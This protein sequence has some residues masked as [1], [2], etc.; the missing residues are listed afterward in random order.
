MWNK[1]PKGTWNTLMEIPDP[2]GQIFPCERWS[3]NKQRKIRKGKKR[4]KVQ[5]RKTSPQV[6]PN[7]SKIC[8]HC[9]RMSDQCKWLH[10]VAKFETNAPSSGQINNYFLCES[11]WY[12]LILG[13]VAVQL[14]LWSNLSLMQW[15]QSG[16]KICNYWDNSSYPIIWVRCF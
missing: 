4:M 15:M 1:F 5:K 14:E 7:C 6:V 11:G 10:L 16:G 12:Q 3:T 13:N 8:D 2:P 9:S